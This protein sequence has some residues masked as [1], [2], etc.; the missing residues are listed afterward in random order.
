METIVYDNP[1]G[2][3]SVRF[4]TVEVPKVDA[5]A[6]RVSSLILTGRAEKVPEQDRRKDNP[7]LVNDVLVYPNL[8]EPVSKKTREVGFFFTV[9]PA[10]G[11]P[12]AEAVLDLLSS[13]KPIGQFPLPLAAASSGRIQQASRLP[14][15]QLVP[16]TYELQVIIKQGAAQIVRTTTFRVI[17]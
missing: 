15:D 5:A 1:T 3:A 6:L 17:D 7:F 14:I 2:K 12:E 10:R 11:G 4:A 16:G 13:G 9:Y 8:G